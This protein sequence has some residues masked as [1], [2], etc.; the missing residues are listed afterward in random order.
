MYYPMEVLEPLEIPE[1]PN[2]ADGLEEEDDIPTPFDLNEKGPNSAS[3][4]DTPRNSPTHETEVAEAVDNNNSYQLRIASAFHSKGVGVIRGPNLSESERRNRKLLPRRRELRVLPKY[5]R[6]PH[7]R[8]ALS[9]VIGQHCQER[10]KPR[11]PLKPSVT[12]KNQ[13]LTEDRGVGLER[14]LDKS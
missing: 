9:G 12:R 10:E 1:P 3:S 13:L 8:P 5:L 6:D 14:T 2:L 4:L 7:P 11:L